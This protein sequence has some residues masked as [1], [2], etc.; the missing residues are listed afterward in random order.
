MRTG[1]KYL[2]RVSSLITLCFPGYFNIHRV[3]ES[4][5]FLLFLKSQLCHEIIRKLEAENLMINDNY[6]FMQ[7]Y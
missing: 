6:L 5:I 2:F 3:E 4:C 1:S 7:W